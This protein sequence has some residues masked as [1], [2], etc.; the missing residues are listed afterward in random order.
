MLFI[1]KGYII[2][3]NCG[4][5]GNLLLVTGVTFQRKEEDGN[6]VFL[7]ILFLSKQSILPQK[8]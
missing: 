5:L 8:L 4:K 2:T 3:V 7:H 1:L 6:C